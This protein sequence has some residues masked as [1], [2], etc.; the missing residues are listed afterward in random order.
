MTGVRIKSSAEIEL[1]R[2]TCRLAAEILHRAADLVRPG[3]TTGEIDDFCRELILSRGA[4]PSPLGYKGYPKSICTS[5]NEEVCHGIPGPRKLREGDIVNLDI[6]TKL[7]G[8]HG[9]TSATFYVGS[10]GADAKHVTEVSRRCLEI[11]IAQVKAGARLFD[12]GAAIQEYAESMGCSVVRDYVGHGVGREFHEPPQVPHFGHRGRGL[13]LKPGMIFTIEPMINFGQ[14]EVRVLDDGWTAV[15]ADG[16]LSAQ[17]EHTV[18]VTETGA[19]VL[20][21]QT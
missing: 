20:T 18:L 21:L 11:A 5:V 16:S 15:T 19:E 6:T 4:I 9:D 1:M 2:S 14:W 7:A 17:F 13:R 10:P 3:V 12:I 8:F